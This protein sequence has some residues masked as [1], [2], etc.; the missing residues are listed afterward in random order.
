MKQLITAQY[1]SLHRHGDLGDM[2][3][4]VKRVVRQGNAVPID[5]NIISAT[6]HPMPIH[7]TAEEMFSQQRLDTLIEHLNKQYDEPTKGK[8]HFQLRGIAYYHLD[9]F[10]EDIPLDAI[11]TDEWHVPDSFTLRVLP[12]Y[13]PYVGE[14]NPLFDPTEIWKD[15]SLPRARAY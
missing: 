10:P 13:Q 6:T 8:L 3:D 11:A 5:I 1:Q 14:Q 15:R 7:G 4:I 9:R 2:Y 12:F